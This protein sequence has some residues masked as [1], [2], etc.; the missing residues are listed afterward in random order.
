MEKT[1]HIIIEALKSGENVDGAW[2]ERLVR[3][4]NRE[5]H[6]GS[7]T[8]AKRRLLP[9]YLAFKQ[10]HPDEW[11]AWG[12]SEELDQAL[13]ALL[14]AKPRRSASGVATVTVLTKPWPC[15][16]QCVFCPNDIRMPKSYLS[17]EPACQ[18]AERCYFD[19][20]LQVISRLRVL[21]DMGHPIDKV[22]L[23]VLGGTWS[24]Y[25]ESYQCWYMAELFRALDLFGSEAAWV[26]EARRRELYR[27]TGLAED[28]DELARYW[29]PVQADIDAGQVSYNEAVAAGYG[30][31]A[32]EDSIP[33]SEAKLTSGAG[34]VKGI[35]DEVCDCRIWECETEPASVIKGLREQAPK[36]DDF[37]QECVS[38]SSRG[39]AQVSTVQAATLDDVHHWQRVNETAGCRCVG[40]VV[41]TR[42][43]LISVPHLRLLRD[44]GCTKIQMGI[45]TLRDELLTCNGRGTS[46]A[47][48]ANAFALLRLFGFKI[49]VHMMTNLVGATLAS[50]AEDYELLVTDG[51][52]LPDEIKL[53]PCALVSSAPLTELYATG[54]WVPYAEEDLVSLLVEDV[55]KTPAYCRISRMIRDIPAPDI[56]AGNKKTNL[57]QMVEAQVCADERPVREIR[58]R[59]IATEVVSV[60]DLVLDEVRYDTAVSEERFLQ[61]VTPEGKIAGF[62]RLSLPKM[63]ACDG[64]GDTLSA[65]GGSTLGEVPYAG[66]MFCAGI[67]PDNCAMIREL[68]IY[69]RVSRLGDA[70]E[71]AQHS[72]LGKKLVAR[73]Q[74][75]A[76]EA[77]YSS[78]AVISA[79]GTREYYRHVGFDDGGLY[80]VMNLD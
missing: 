43:D 49:H 26:E 36:A 58:M 10:N 16:G 76:R 12:V 7:R 24:N 67:L 19:P 20:F 61:W 48:I 51:R 77:G 14:R 79:V 23:I 75:I 54:V 69:G 6:D 46:V 56:L 71:G 47:M 52:F 53:Y 55:L 4:R 50:D 42:P 38:E 62:M 73:A 65:L 31:G 29:A 66:A 13:V 35:S 41:E 63:R 8:V 11:A 15:V 9:Y 34:G 57:R 1:L 45:Q 2:L 18:R 78:L 37:K 21:A 70:G 68:H 44:F 39:W 59:E 17:D 3:R 27:A 22:E 40:L 80:Q 25:P 72:G 33:K 74:V 60:E 28:P 64:Q 5:M 30:I 32:H